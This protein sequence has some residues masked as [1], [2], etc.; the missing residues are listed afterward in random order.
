MAFSSTGCQS[1]VGTAASSASGSVGPGDAHPLAKPDLLDLHVCFDEVQLLTERH[2]LVAGVVEREPEE[3][4]EA[5]DH[6]VR[7][8]RIGVHQLGRGIQRVEE[9]MRLELHL[10]H[11]QLRLREPGLE[12]GRLELARPRQAGP[13]GGLGERQHQ[14]AAEQAGVESAA[15]E[16]GPRRGPAPG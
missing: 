12:L 3:L 7:R 6:Q 15:E 2:D 14:Q 4:P 16:H 9:E 13:A 5:G 11:L 8:P 1:S 10:E